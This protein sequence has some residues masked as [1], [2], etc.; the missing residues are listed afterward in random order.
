[1]ANPR[2][3]NIV[4]LLSFH[5]TDH[6]EERRLADRMNE[7]SDDGSSYEYYSDYEDEEFNYSYN[8]S[9]YSKAPLPDFS[10]RELEASK[11]MRKWLKII[12]EMSGEDVDAFLEKKQIIE[13]G[14]SSAIRE[15]C[16]A[17]LETKTV[18]KIPGFIFEQNKL[19]L[20][21]L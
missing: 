15:C 17:A 7:E 1:M 20:N 9:P 6:C 19:L 21:L 16:S 12:T 11:A 8:L 4:R 2:E 13:N 10:E 3:H 5:F 14:N 18:Y